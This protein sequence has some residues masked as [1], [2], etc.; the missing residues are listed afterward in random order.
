[1]VHKVNSSSYRMVAGEMGR[2][3]IDNIQ[4]HTVAETI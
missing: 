2:A 3:K 1:M 4:T